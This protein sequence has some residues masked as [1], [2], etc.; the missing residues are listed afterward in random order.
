MDKINKF[1]VVIV[2]FSNCSIL[3]SQ[4]YIS[5]DPYY[6]LFHEE[7]ALKKNSELGA[8][9]LRPTFINEN[10]LNNKLLMKYR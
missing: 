5:A 9:S 4:N 1:I 8:L 3:L 10:E 2:I 6:Y 7:R